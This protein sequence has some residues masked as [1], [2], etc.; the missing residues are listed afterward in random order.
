MI[1]TI[2]KTTTKKEYPDLTREE[3]KELV[4]YLNQGLSEEEA[5]AKVKGNA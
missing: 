1:A 5:I 2:K 4:K 3:I